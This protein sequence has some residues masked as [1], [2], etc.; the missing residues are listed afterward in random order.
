MGEKVTLE[1]L[2]SRFGADP[3]EFGGKVALE[4]FLS[5]F[6][7]DP[8]ESLLSHF[9]VTFMICVFGPSIGCIPKGSYGNTAF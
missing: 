2:L 3:V 1:S 5:H 8:V 4:S 7:P 6:G 9:F